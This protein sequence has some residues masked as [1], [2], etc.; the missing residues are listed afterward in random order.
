MQRLAEDHAQRVLDLEV[1]RDAAG[2]YEE[3]RNYAKEVARA[4]ED[5]TAGGAE[6]AAEFAQER[7]RRAAEFAQEQADTLTEYETQRQER[8]TQAA[9]RA[10]ELQTAA[11]VE[12]AALRADAFAKL[13]AEFGYYA[14]SEAQQAQHNAALLA[15]AEA[16][17]LQ[18]GALWSGWAADLA[19]SFAAA[20]SSVT[21]MMGHEQVA[22]ADGYTATLGGYAAGGYV[23]QPGAYQLAE[24]GREFVLNADTTARLEREGGPLTQGGVGVGRAL[25]IA[26][27]VQFTGGAPLE[28]AAVGVVVERVIVQALREAGLTR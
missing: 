6:R 22:V 17:L 7:E 28:P 24:R 19:N 25:T 8:I 11:D 5:Y 9:V 4:E 10:A 12:L 18:N 14:A 13:N 1:A 23:S 16:F 21:S 27:T 26:P 15:G 20:W 2:L 3:N